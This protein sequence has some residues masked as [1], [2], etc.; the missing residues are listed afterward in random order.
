MHTVDF[1]EE[2]FRRQVREQEYAL[3][4]FE[5]LALDHLRGA[6]I[7]LGCGLGNLSLESARRGHETVA[8]DASPTAVARITAAAEK[9][10]LRLR[11]VQA[12]IATWH[13]DRNYDTVVAIGLLM[14][15]HRARALELLQAV[16]EHVTPGG[17]AIVN[18]LIEGTTYTG[19]FDPDDHY[20]FGAHEL[21]DRFAGWSL[22][23]SLHQTFS[24]PDDK[25]KVFATI[26]AEKPVRGIGGAPGG[27]CGHP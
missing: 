21:E 13:M 27:G 12:D 8:V 18:V 10:G 24:A 9:E 17:C 22:L 2:Q 16:Q 1:F 26:V 23:A 14:F 4:P 19:M 5:L 11:A 3:N 25:L 15:F 7:D 6:V 20:L